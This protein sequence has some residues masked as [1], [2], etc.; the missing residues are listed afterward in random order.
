MHFKLK[1]SHTAG[2]ISDADWHLQILYTGHFFPRLETSLWFLPAGAGRQRRGEV[3]RV[4]WETPQA[5][6]KPVWCSIFSAL[7]ASVLLP[8]TWL[9]GWWSN[10]AEVG[11][12]CP[13]LAPLPLTLYTSSWVRL[14]RETGRSSVT[15]LRHT[16]GVLDRKLKHRTAPS[17]DRAHHKDTKFQIQHQNTGRWSSSW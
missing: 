10:S 6:S 12:P 13:L 15:K 4:D 3:T 5:L 9:L 1:V 14:S 11:F 8:S 17:N 7:P 16:N 2:Q